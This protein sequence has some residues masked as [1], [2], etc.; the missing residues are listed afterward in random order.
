VFAL[1]GATME[2]SFL[3]LGDLLLAIALFFATMIV[4]F[5]FAERRRESR[6]E[7]QL[8]DAIERE[9]EAFFQ[10]ERVR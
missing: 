10:I 9:Y 3:D 6:R 8:L 1:A 7:Q 5:E 2:M 4:I